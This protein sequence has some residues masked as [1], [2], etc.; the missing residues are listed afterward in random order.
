MTEKFSFR[1]GPRGGGEGGARY[2]HLTGP[3]GVGL[4]N[5]QK[6]SKIIVSISWRALLEGTIILLKIYIFRILNL[7]NCPR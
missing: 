3:T 1:A 7:P 6:L 2:R 5:T 4:E